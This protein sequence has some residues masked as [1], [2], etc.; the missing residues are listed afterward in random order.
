MRPPEPRPYS[1][2]ARARVALSMAAREVS[3]SARGMVP[4][5]AD[6]YAEPGEFV[7]HALRLRALVDHLLERAV[8]L[9]RERNTTWEAI[10]EGLGGVGE[11]RTRQTAEARFGE[12]VKRWKAALVTP[13]RPHSDGESVYCALPDGAEDPGRWAAVLDEW[14]RRHAE[15]TDVLAHS[16]EE[17]PVSAGLDT[18]PLR[19]VVT[20]E[21]FILDQALD[22][23]ARRMVGEPPIEAEVA[24]FHR[25][26]RAMIDWIDEVLPAA[27]RAS[28]RELLEGTRKGLV[29]L[30]ELVPPVP[31]P[32]P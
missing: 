11:R 22:L 20:E 21:R 19:L 6:R 3:D 26:R 14:A 23:Q 30:T 13:W 9:E 17:Q 29:G 27:D 4:T 15:P 18:D 10:G 25:R 31:E 28:T 8:I 16:G 1:A 24:A 5:T 7:E 2:E 32:T 12:A